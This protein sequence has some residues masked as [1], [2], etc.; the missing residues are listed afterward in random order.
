M[1]TILC[2]RTGGLDLVNELRGTSAPLWRR[3][4]WAVGLC[5]QPTALTMAAEG[6]PLGANQPVVQVGPGVCMR[7]R[8]SGPRR[9]GRRGSV[10][11]ARENGWGEESMNP[12]RPSVEQRQGGPL[13]RAMVDK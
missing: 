6:L 12:R 8:K 2:I 9:E 5:S 7:L 3:H 10:K 1:G 13:S 4:G 11:A